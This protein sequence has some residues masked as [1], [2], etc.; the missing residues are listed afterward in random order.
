MYLVDTNVICEPTQA[1]PTSSVLE[2]LRSQPSLRLSVVSLM[3]I[4]YGIARLPK[5]AKRERLTT[6]FEALAASEGIALVPVD[7]AIARAAGRLRREAEAKGKQRPALNL[8]IAATA[9]VTGSVVATRNT[10][11]FEG[12]GIPLLN[13]YR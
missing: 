9:L 3:E 4:E 5:G 2:W 11:D 1:Q 12:L 13:P 6:W 8:L 7:A 10:A